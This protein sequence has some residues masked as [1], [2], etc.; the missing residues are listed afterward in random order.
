[1]YSKHRMQRRA[2]LLPNDQAIHVRDEYLKKTGEFVEHH[3]NRP[4]PDANVFRRLQQLLYETGRVT[5]TASVNAG[6]RSAV[7]TPGQE[8][9]IIAAVA[10]YT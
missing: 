4:P 3:P 1:M 9:A 10:G 7:R 6:R 2:Q 8:D 5:M